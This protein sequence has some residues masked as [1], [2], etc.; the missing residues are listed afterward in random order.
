MKTSYIT[1]II[2]FCM[3][4]SCNPHEKSDD[5]PKQ[6]KQDILISFRMYPRMCG[7]GSDTRNS[8]NIINDSL[9]VIYYFGLRK[10]SAGI[11]IIDETNSKYS[12]Q[13]TSIQLDKI[14]N[15]VSAV[16][17][18]YIYQG[19]SGGWSYTPDCR[20]L[21]MINRNV[22]FEASDFMVKKPEL[23]VFPD[24]TIRIPDDIM[25]LINYLDTLA[26]PLLYL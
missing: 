25:N 6:I 1:L 14:N 9:I 5:A 13:L 10:D 8:I 17:T 23:M 7:S 16:K 26:P 20:A 22:F 24:E 4:V 3:I 12:T 19:S 2:L 18:S 21:L 11:D 15:L